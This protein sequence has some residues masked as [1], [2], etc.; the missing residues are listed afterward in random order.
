MNRSRFADIDNETGICV[1]P[2]KKRLV[3]S[4]HSDLVM[5][6]YGPEGV[7][8]LTIKFSKSGFTWTGK[9]TKSI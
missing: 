5:L 6:T 1:M 4:A 7:R 3:I 9:N 8:M 2:A